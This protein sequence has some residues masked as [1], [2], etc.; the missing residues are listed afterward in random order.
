M[1]LNGVERRVNENSY[2][3]AKPGIE[4]EWRGDELHLCCC[5]YVYLSFA[6]GPS[7]TRKGILFWNYV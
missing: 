2:T 1:N 7:P 3:W 6:Q 5:K 4:M